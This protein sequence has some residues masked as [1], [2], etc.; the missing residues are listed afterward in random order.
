ME[1]NSKSCLVREL[2]VSLQRALSH[3]LHWIVILFFFPHPNRYGVLEYKRP[4]TFS[5]FPRKF[6]N[7]KRNNN[8]WRFGMKDSGRYGKHLFL[9]HNWTGRKFLYLSFLKNSLLRAHWNKQ[10]F[11]T[12]PKNSLFLNSSIP[13]PLQ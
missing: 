6:W 3:L 1:V 4:F 13:G 11:G 5:S 8:M 10:P 2:T 7:L 9:N 12:N